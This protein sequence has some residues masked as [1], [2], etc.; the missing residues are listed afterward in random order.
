MRRH[1]LTEALFGAFIFQDA[2]IILWTGDQ[3]PH[4]I[5]DQ[6]ID[7]NLAIINV[8]VALMKE[9]FP[10]TPIF[11]VVGNHEAWPVNM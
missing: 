9:Y 2:D 8:T 5:W 3:P 1:R 11:P 4:D 7:E 6:S 10:S